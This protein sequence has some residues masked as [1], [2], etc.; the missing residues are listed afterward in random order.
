M[1]KSGLPSLTRHAGRIVRFAAPL[2]RIRYPDGMY[3]NLRGF[4]DW[5]PYARALV[6]IAGRLPDQPRRSVDEARVVDVLAANQVMADSA[7]PLWKDAEPG[8][9]ATPDGWVWAHVGAGGARADRSEGEGPRR[10]ALVPAEA[11]AAFRHIGHVAGRGAGDGSRGLT[12]QPPAERPSMIPRRTKATEADVAELE[13]KL[14]A[15]LP[16]P[17]RNFLLAGN[18]GRPATPLAHPGFGFL[19]DQSFFGF[20][21]KDWFANVTNARQWL[22]DRFAGDFLPIGHVQG[23]LLAVRLSPPGPG[24]VCYYDDDDP[25]DD[26][27]YDAEAVGA[28]LLRR[29]A[30]SFDEFLDALAPVPDGLV[31]AAQSMVAGGMAQ[32]VVDRNQGGA[33]PRDRRPPTSGQ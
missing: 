32:R 3:V 4:P 26:E 31:A 29:C 12:M 19:V 8:A 27:S 30:D 13:A 10:L 14:E 23:G 1:T 22:A 9:A 17:Y 5:T 28:H 20:R 21:R 25:A 11:H 2:L 7:D 24:S 15:G 18:G 16:A 6:E 33:L